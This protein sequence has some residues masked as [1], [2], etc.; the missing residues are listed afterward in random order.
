MTTRHARRKG[1]PRGSAAPA[2]SLDLAPLLAAILRER[3][4][5]RAAERVGMSQSAL[6][7]VLAKLRDV[8]G[9]PLLVRTSRGAALTPRAEALAEPLARALAELERLLTNVEADPARLD[10]RF[11]IA[12]PDYVAWVLLPG[13]FA[14]VSREAPAVD[15]ELRPLDPRTVSQQLETGEVDLAIGGVQDAAPDLIRRSLFRESFSCLVRKGH[16]AT[17]GRFTL[18][19]YLAYPHALVGLRT[20]VPGL[21]DLALEAL[22]QRR[23]VAVRLPY[24]LLAPVIVARSDLVLTVPHHLAAHLSK[25]HGLEVLAPPLDLPTTEIVATWHV[26]VAADPAHQWFRELVTRVAAK[27][28]RPRRP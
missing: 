8:L 28:R 13:L 11:V 10:R 12:A 27:V 19:R 20:G 15:L 17:R 18:A 5:T 9:D 4:V 25:L 3:S 1:R 14:E 22:G 21:V 26:R 16:P 24:F 6:S 23:R 2:M 7:H